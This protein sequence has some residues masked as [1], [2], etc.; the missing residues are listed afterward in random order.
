VIMNSTYELCVSEQVT[1]HFEVFPADRTVDNRHPGEPVNQS[2][3]SGSHCAVNNRQRRSIL[4][5]VLNS[6]TNKL[7]TE[8]ITDVKNGAFTIG[9]HGFD[10]NSDGVV[11]VADQLE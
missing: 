10:V 11:L 6:R 1:F 9:K 7:L 5:D 3:R 8:W 2:G 4:F